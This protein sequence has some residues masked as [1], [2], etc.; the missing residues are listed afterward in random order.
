MHVDLHLVLPTPAFG[1]FKKPLMLGFSTGSTAASS[2]RT[3]VD[4]AAEAQ[5]AKRARSL[6]SP[7]GSLSRS[8]SA[9]DLEAGGAFPPLFMPGGQ[10]FGTG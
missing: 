6:R 9:M 4:A 8:L 10:H 1:F 7:A 5:A 2:L 3:A